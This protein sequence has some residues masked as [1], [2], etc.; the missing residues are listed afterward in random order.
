ME[1]PGADHPCETFRAF[2]RTTITVGID[3]NLWFTE[4]NEF[5]TPNPD[6]GGTFQ[7]RIG[8]IT[9]AGEITEYRVDGC[10]C[11]LNDIV[12]GPD[13]VLY[14][15]TNNQDLGAQRRREMS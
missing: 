14:F 7:N 4:G 13:N 11:F 2:P 9:P 6:T 10:D 15:T 1:V 3:G 5:F 8:K 12:Q